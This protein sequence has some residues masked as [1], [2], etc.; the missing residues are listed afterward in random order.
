MGEYILQ[1][2]MQI[3]LIGAWK[4]PRDLQT[5]W[6]QKLTRH[7][8]KH[9][10]DQVNCMGMYRLGYVWLN[11]LFVTSLYEGAACAQQKDKRPNIIYIMSD[12]HGYQAI[13]A[14]GYGLNSTPNI[15]RLAREGAIFTN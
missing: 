14:Y 7:K 2:L 11:L 13:S 3:I 9:K 5:G 12:D 1:E 6:Q 15:D 8:S 4:L 10:Q